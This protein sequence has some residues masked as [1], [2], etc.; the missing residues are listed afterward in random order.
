MVV[1]DDVVDCCLSVVCDERSLDLQFDEQATRD[2]WVQTLIKAVT[3]QK[4]EGPVATL[5]KP[6]PVLHSPA[7]VEGGLDLYCC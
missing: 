1:S 5:A 6:A 2:C 4:A 3:A 7:A